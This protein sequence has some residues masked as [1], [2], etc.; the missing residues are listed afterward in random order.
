MHKPRDIAR[1]GANDRTY[2]GS[3]Q[4]PVPIRRQGYR[5]AHRLLRSWWFIA[6]P[7]VRGVKCAL[8]DGE[9]VLLVRHTYGH[10][11]WDLPGG[12]IRRGEEPAEA[13]QREMEEEL[14]VRIDDL[15]PLGDISIRPYRAH[16][17]IYCFHAELGS[18]ELTID[19]GELADARW[20]RRAEMPAALSR[21]VRTILARVQPG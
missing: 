4:V 3:V 17:R 5:I 10:P 16:E 6:R 15:R 19:R 12:G 21:Y 8:T 2:A 13:A 11:E 1:L 7:Q 20:F 9:R 18:P 14:G